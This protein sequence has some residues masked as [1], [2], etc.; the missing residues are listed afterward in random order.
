MTIVNVVGPV[1]YGQG[2]LATLDRLNALDTVL[3]ISKIRRMRLLLNDSIPDIKANQVWTRTG[4]VF[5]NGGQGVIVGIIDTGIEYRSLNFRKPDGSTRLLSLWDQTLTA[6]TGESAPGPI[7]IPL[8]TDPSHPT[9]PVNLQYGVAYTDSQINAY[10]TNDSATPNIRH[11]DDDGHGSH[12]SG[13]AAGSGV[14]RGRCH[15]TY[16]YVGVAPM[17]DLIV[18]R[19]WGL[20][21]GDSKKPLPPGLAG[22]TKID[23]IMYILNE[24][25][26][27]GKPVVMNLSLGLFTADLTGTGG[28]SLSMDALLKANTA[29]FAL[30]FGAGNDADSR[31]H[32]RA[33]VPAG[34][35]AS[36]KLPFKIAGSDKRGRQ[37]VTRYTGSNLR[38]RLSSDEGTT[39]WVSSTDPTI[40]FPRPANPDKING[41]GGSVDL[42]NTTNE[43]YVVISPPPKGS[44]V[45]GTW[46]LEFNSSTPV[47]TQVDA[48]W[49][50]SSWHDEV[51]PAHFTEH[52]S[53]QA[54]LTEAA[55]T[56]E[57][58][59]VGAYAVSNGGLAGFSSRG[60]TAGPRQKPEITA[61]GVSIV[62]TDSGDYRGCCNWLCCRCCFY[63][64]LDGTSM[65]APHVTGAV[66]LMLQRNNAL[67]HTQI[68][69]ILMTTA[70]PVA[71][72]DADDKLGWGRG[73]LDVK[74]AVDKAQ[75]TA[76]VAPPAPVP[77]P[78]P[79]ATLPPSQADLLQQRVVS[80]PRWPE[81]QALYDRY[82][83]ELR[84]LVN[85][86]KRVATVW[87]RNGGPAW[88]RVALQ[89]T[90]LPSMPIPAVAGGCT[91]RDAID[92]MRA[93]I[94]R[95][96][97][98]AL[99]QDLDRYAPFFAL[100][101]GGQSLLQLLNQ[102]EQPE[103]LV[104]AD[105]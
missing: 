97:S 49:Q 43:I 44:N 39:G 13:I 88:V 82:A 38:V 6:T 101:D 65:A 96:G 33:T 63:K 74:A 42:T 8:G 56:R 80:N 68:T 2:S 28:D 98:P 77:S 21:E 55:A 1:A 95:Y 76:P 81:F 89:L 29:G 53:P 71:T 70:R 92:R 23:A 17:A 67:P 51:N 20:T 79:F 72:S 75:A 26:K 69:D 52:Q 64:N 7:T 15:G 34:P 35:A 47:T 5:T 103:H 45:K 87:H 30:V 90:S 60:D 11:E 105:T 58:I 18:V 83:D 24:A 27:R 31:F 86:N 46:T 40:T 57:V 36:L 16:T 10:L 9:R 73:K 100:F 99:C 19:L 102:L 14:Q 62:S 12:V 50:N 85:T 78:T 41:D 94:G 3:T 32:A 59:A 22:S 54:T 93:I 25:K 37:L 4:D 91:L 104:S 84:I 66:A 61:P 48:F